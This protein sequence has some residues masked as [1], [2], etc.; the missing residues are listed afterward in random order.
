MASKVFNFNT[1]E[2]MAL[3]HRLALERDRDLSTEFT[4]W[5]GVF[6]HDLIDF[7]PPRPSKN[8]NAAAV[9]IGKRPNSWPSQKRAGEGAVER[10]IRKVFRSKE[11]LMDVLHENPVIAAKPKLREFV[12]RAVTAGDGAALSRVLHKLNIELRII[13]APLKEQHFAARTGKKKHVPKRTKGYYVLGDGVQGYVNTIKRDV[14]KLKSGF[15]T[16]AKQAGLHVNNIPAWVKRHHEPGRGVANL[17]GPHYFVRLH[18]MCRSGR[19][20]DANEIVGKAI[21]II[22]NKMKKSLLAITKHWRAKYG[23]R[24]V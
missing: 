4:Q 19:D 20:Q 16:A 6:A 9:A 10:D 14:G 1:G 2:R 5:A 3:L 22:E 7:C 11:D 18:N 17:R 24:P 13:P 12:D 8:S 21:I 15:L 23:S